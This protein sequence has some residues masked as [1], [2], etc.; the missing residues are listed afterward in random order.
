[1][2]SLQIKAVFLRV[3]WESEIN[4]LLYTLHHLVFIR[5]VFYVQLEVFFP[6]LDLKLSFLL[7]NKRLKLLNR[8]AFEKISFQLN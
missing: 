2:V 8:F 7:E 1:M 6:S 4:Y 3:Q 5:D